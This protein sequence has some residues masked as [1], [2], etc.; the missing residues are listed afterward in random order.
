[1]TETLNGKTPRGRLRQRWVNTV[2]SNL[3]ICGPGSRLEESE[4][5]ERWREIVLTK[6]LWPKGFKSLKKKNYLYI[7]NINAN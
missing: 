1:V 7:L 6:V 2:K 4:D 3:Y 5:R